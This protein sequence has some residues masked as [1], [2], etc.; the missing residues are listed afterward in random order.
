[1]SNK[2]IGQPIPYLHS[3]WKNTQW[4]LFAVCYMYISVIYMDMFGWNSDV[5][6]L[7]KLLYK[8]N[9][10]IVVFDNFI[11]K[12]FRNIVILFEIFT[13]D[14]SIWIW[15]SGNLSLTYTHLNSIMGKLI[16]GSVDLL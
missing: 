5:I 10:I 11:Q 4:A 14:I 12:V 15:P 9:V 16:Q 1:M 6:Y 7:Q 8:I 2:Y 3:L 13:Y